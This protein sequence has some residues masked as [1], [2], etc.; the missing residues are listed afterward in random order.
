MNGYPSNK[1]SGQRAFSLGYYEM[2]LA[3]IML[4]EDDVLTIGAKSDFRHITIGSC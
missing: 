4:A 1:S 3:E 2:E